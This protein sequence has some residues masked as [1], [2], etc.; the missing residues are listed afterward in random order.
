MMNGKA[1]GVLVVFGVLFCCSSLFG[2]TANGRVSGT[3]KD[4]TG[5]LIPGAPLTITDTKEE[6]FAYTVQSERRL[7]AH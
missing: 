1:V 2:Q 7:E 3:V 4:G 6:G 5:G